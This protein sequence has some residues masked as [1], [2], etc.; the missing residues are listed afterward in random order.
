MIRR[1]RTLDWLIPL[2]VVIALGVLAYG[3][4]IV[5]AMTLMLIPAG[6]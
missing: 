3:I 6:D 5:A 2:L 4:L 1:P